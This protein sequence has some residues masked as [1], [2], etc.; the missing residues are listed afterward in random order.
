MN[1]WLE[2]PWEE[3]IVWA[4]KNKKFSSDDLRLS[5]LWITNP[6]S[7]L[8]DIIEFKKGQV[9]LGPSDLQLIMDGIY[10]TKAIEEDDIGLALGCMKSMNDRVFKLHNIEPWKKLKNIKYNRG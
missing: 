7:E 3:R 10:L 4:I 9:Y 5:M 1:T 6:I 2:I 8:I